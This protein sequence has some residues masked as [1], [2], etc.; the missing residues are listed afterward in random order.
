MARCSAC[1]KMSPYRAMAELS[2]AI[3][4]MDGRPKIKWHPR[5]TPNGCI[6]PCLV[7][8]SLAWDYLARTLGWAP[9]SVLTQF[10][11]QLSWDHVAEIIELTWLRLLGWTHL[12]GITWLRSLGWDLWDLTAITWPSSHGWDKLTLLSG[13]SS[14]ETTEITGLNPLHWKHLAEITEITW[15][16]SLGWDHLDE[17]TWLR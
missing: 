14:L 9:V 7:W 10:L 4:F 16:K 6:V 13:L 3:F 11:G 17:I 15:M 8:G 1:L 2:I 12:A 5:A